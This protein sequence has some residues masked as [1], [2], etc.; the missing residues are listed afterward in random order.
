[1]ITERKQLVRVN[2]HDAF[3]GA[4]NSVEKLLNEGQIKTAE[5]LMVNGYSKRHFDKAQGIAFEWI[6]D[7]VEI[8]A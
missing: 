4:T 6:I 2:M 3:S 5:W 8:L 1:M 7:E